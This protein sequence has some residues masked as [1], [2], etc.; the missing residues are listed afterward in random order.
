MFSDIIFEQK[1]AY[2]LIDL[3]MIRLTA[4]LL[5]TTAG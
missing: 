4:Y 1:D 5:T 2:Q 3:Y